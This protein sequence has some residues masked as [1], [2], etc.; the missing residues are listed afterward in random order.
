MSNIIKFDKKNVAGQHQKLSNFSKTNQSEI[1][2]RERFE[3]IEKRLAK[4]NQLIEE[5]K[6]CGVPVSTN[7]ENI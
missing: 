4:I 3:K 2:N 1:S 7:Q 5:L 6:Q